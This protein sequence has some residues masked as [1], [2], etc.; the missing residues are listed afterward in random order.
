VV[1]RR[2]VI[3]GDAG[4]T[5]VEIM[6]VVAI[7]GILVVMAVPIYISAQVRASQRTCY[8]N[9][10]QLEGAVGVWIAADPERTRTQLAGVV[11]AAHPLV[12]EHIVGRPPRCP[13]A[14][15][16]VDPDNPTV[17]QGAYT[18]GTEGT[19]APCTWGELGPHGHY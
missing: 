10:R 16:A 15:D 5:V 17:A 3:S 6:V 11:N 4:F 2:A 8:A 19:L 1:S 13:S 18:L 9:Q 12:V 14:A 7:I